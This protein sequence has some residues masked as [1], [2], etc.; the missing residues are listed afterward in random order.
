MALSLALPLPSS[1]LKLSNVNG[2]EV[3]HK[4]C[5]VEERSK[6][7]HMEGAFSYSVFPAICFAFA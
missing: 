7:L 2:D 5:D 4:Q 1:F 3:Y 6:K